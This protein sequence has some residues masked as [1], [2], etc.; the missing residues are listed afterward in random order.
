MLKCEN[1]TLCLFHTDYVQTEKSLHAT[2]IVWISFYKVLA[3]SLFVCLPLIV[4][5]ERK[6]K[7]VEQAEKLNKIILWFKKLHEK[8]PFLLDT[9]WFKLSS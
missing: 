7:H 9:C 6:R 3:W 1:S 2:Y 8:F 4:N 5:H